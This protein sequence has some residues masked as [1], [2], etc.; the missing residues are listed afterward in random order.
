[1]KI[2]V[3]GGFDERNEELLK[4]QQKFAK[5]LG[6]EII[7]QGHVLLNACLTSF[8]AAIAESAYH[9]AKKEGR[10]PNERII[11]YVLQGQKLAH[12]FGN[13]PQSQ[14]ENWELGGPRLRVPEPSTLPM[15]SF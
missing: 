5:L 13:I 9:T 11:C 8:D 2:L 7:L 4:T 1:M 6:R 14:L 3:A 15:R 10:D 12:D